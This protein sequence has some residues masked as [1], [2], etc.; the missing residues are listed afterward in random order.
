MAMM[1][2]SLEIGVHDDRQR[3]PDTAVTGAEKD[4]VVSS[5]WLAQAMLW[6]GVSLSRPLLGWML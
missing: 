6:V 4:A 2:L 5:C 1:V 3:N